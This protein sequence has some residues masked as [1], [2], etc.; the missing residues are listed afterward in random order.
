MRDLLFKHANKTKNVWAL[1]TKRKLF[2][3][4]VTLD[5]PI[6]PKGKCFI[7]FFFNFERFVVWIQFYNTVK[8]KLNM[9]NCNF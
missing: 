2:C 3:L 8:S 6:I 5:L 1:P 4:V 7:D 9:P